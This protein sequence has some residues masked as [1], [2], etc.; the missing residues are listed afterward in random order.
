MKLKLENLIFLVPLA[1]MFLF[2][3]C[4]DI[5]LKSKIPEYQYFYIPA[6]TS[7]ALDPKCIDPYRVILLGNSASMSLDS[8]DIFIQDSNSLTMSKLIGKKWIKN[9]TSMLA[10]GLRMFLAPSCINLQ[11]LPISNIDNQ[12]F[13]KANIAKLFIKENSVMVNIEYEILDP[14]MKLLKFGTIEK[15]VKTMVNSSPNAQINT[16]QDTFSQAIKQLSNTIK[17]IKKSRQK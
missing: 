2:G 6:D 11:L 10:D 17:T 14:K 3:G 13:I 4:I 9:P 1:L 16:L 7:S 15:E 5:N 8:S 12:L